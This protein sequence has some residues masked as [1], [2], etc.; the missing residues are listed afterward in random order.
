MDKFR[1]E[2]KGMTPEERVAYIKQE[3][4]EDTIGIPAPV[5]AFGN[6]LKKGEKIVLDGGGGHPTTLLLMGD[7][8]KEGR[9]DDLK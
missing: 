3:Y 1:E 9:F 2:T 8:R 4:G 7:M 5:V 6:K